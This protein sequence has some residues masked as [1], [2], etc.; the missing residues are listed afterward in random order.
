MIE[1][2]EVPSKNQYTRLQVGNHNNKKESNPSVLAGYGR[3]S[4]PVP[5]QEQALGSSEQ[6]TGTQESMED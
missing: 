4:T 3:Q 2:C 1:E 5:G 6:R